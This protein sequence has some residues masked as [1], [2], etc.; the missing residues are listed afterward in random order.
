MQA[1]SPRGPH[2]TVTITLT[3]TL[4]VINKDLVIR[5]KYHV[6]HQTF[7]LFIYLCVQAQ[8]FLFYLLGYNLL[9]SF[10]SVLKLSPVCP[11]E[12]I[13]GGFC[14]LLT[15]LHHSFCT[16]LLWEHKEIFPGS[17]CTSSVP[18]LESAIN[19]KSPGSFR[20]K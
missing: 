18:A 4:F 9:L 16:S 11:C 3:L 10:I 12:S 1:V 2:F 6:T 7:N 14:V 5:C 17:S 8:D 19:P 15:H 13:Q 20:G